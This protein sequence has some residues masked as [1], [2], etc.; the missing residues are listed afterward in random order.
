MSKTSS[1]QRSEKAVLRRNCF[2]QQLVNSKAKLYNYL[3]APCEALV[4]PLN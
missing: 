1:A 2:F 3:S 4:A